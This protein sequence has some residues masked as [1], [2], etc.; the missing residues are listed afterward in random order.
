[1]NYIKNIDFQVLTNGKAFY[2]EKIKIAMIHRYE[3]ILEK[4][5]I[6]NDDIFL[7]SFLYVRL[8]D[9]L[10]KNLPTIEQLT[11]GYQTNSNVTSKIYFKFNPKGIA[12]FNN[13]F[14]IK[15]RNQNVF[16]NYCTAVFYGI[17]LKEVKFNNTNIS[18][19]IIPF[20]YLDKNSEI[21]LIQFEDNVFNIFFVADHPKF[22]NFGQNVMPEIENITKHC[23]NELKRA[24]EFIETQMPQVFEQIKVTTKKIIVFDAPSVFSF[25]HHNLHDAILISSY[26]SASFL[27]FIDQ[28]LHQASHNIL[29]T[30]CFEPSSYFKQPVDDIPLSKYSANIR[31]TRSIFGAFHGVLNHAHCAI[32]FNILENN[33]SLYLNPIEQHELTGRFCELNNRHRNGIEKIEIHDFFTNKGIELYIELNS[34]LDKILLHT[35]EK[36]RLYNFSSQPTDFDF[37]VFLTLNPI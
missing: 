36:Y 10:N 3:A 15:C 2:A 26:K 33:N 27:F 35:K 24:I 18:F 8:C 25:V 4:L 20:I 37:N 9:D 5:D 16:N 22:D 13:L 21:E 7:D 12:R 17:D 1:M 29:N 28:I 30:L 23:S 11:F 31:E 6:Y 14:Y 32:A 19:E 34:L